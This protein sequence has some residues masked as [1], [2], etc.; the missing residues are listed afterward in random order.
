MQGT[1]A[2]ILAV[3]A[4]VA[5]AS[6]SDRSDGKLRLRGAAGARLQAAAAPSPATRAFRFRGLVFAVPAAWKVQ[7][8]G[9]LPFR[10]ERVSVTGLPSGPRL[11]FSDTVQ[12]VRDGSVMARAAGAPLGS[13]LSM[14]R[15]E[16]PNPITRAVTYV[17]PEAGVSI[18]AQVRTDDEARA[19]DAVAQSA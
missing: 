11:T 13:G 3:A 10:T 18:S 19:A 17:F 15:F 16:M 7:R 6:G 5:A 9:S 8:A 4:A 2:A 14:Q 12:F 1:V